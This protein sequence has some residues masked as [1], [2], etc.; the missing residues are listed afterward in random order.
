MTKL[1]LAMARAARAALPALLAHVRLHLHGA[2]EEAAYQRRL[3]NWG[4][5]EA[6]ILERRRRF[7][8]EHKESF[9]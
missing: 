3:Q 7:L 6:D 1:L 2:R 4:L 9:R 8:D 5:T